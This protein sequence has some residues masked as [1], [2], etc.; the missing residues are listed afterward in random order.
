MDRL[1]LVTPPTLV[2][3]SDNLFEPRLDAARRPGQPP[4][5]TGSETY[6]FS[7]EGATSMVSPP[8]DPLRIF[9]GSCTVT[10]PA[11]W[12]VK[13]TAM[14]C[15]EIRLDLR[16]TSW[17]VI[18]LS[19]PIM[20]R[21]F[22]GMSIG[23]LTGA[24]VV[25]AEEPGTSLALEVPVD[26][27]VAEPLAVEDEVADAVAE[28]VAVAD[29]VA[30]ADDDAE[31]DGLLDDPINTLDAADVVTLIRVSLVTLLLTIAATSSALSPDL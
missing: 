29:E 13:V 27:A 4:G 18:P 3:G 25:E 12:N 22:A 6:S 9:T 19:P 1:G 24:E 8:V 2:A 5:R 26:D 11:D 16:P 28:P 21:V 23:V 7:P 30:D 20:I 17:T 15:P 31:S 10:D 14:V